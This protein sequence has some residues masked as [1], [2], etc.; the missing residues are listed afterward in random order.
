MS[1]ELKKLN[2]I[3]RNDET[4][5]KQDVERVIEDYE[6]THGKISEPDYLA[7]REKLFGSKPAA[8]GTRKSLE[9]SY[10]LLISFMIIIGA[11]TVAYASGIN[12]FT[13]IVRVFKEWQHSDTPEEQDLIASG[14]MTQYFSLEEVRQAY[15]EE[16]ILLPDLEPEDYKIDLI[17]DINYGDFRSIDLIY[18]NGTDT[19]LCSIIYQFNDRDKLMHLPHIGNVNG[20]SFEFQIGEF[21]GR[22]MA[23][24]AGTTL[25]W[26]A[27]AVLYYITGKFSIESLETFIGSFSK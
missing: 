8:K 25:S 12:I 7:S 14:N 18:T 22:Y 2:Q 11:G 23:A 19:L 13:E 15:A 21:A 5:N 1:I 16:D 4:I 27:E 24:G 20:S 6:K 3:L 17:R 26:E 10:V 9:F